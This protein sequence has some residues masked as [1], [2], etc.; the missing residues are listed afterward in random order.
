MQFRTLYAVIFD[1]KGTLTYLTEEEH[2]LR[3]RGAEAATETL[4]AAGLTLPRA[5]FVDKYLEALTFAERK[6][7]L[8]QEE[9]LATDTL[10]FLLQFYG[11]PHPDPALIRRAVDATYAPVVEASALY[12]DAMIT[13]Q[14]LR[15]RGLK[16]GIL[17]NTQD[18]NAAHAIVSRLG[19]DAQVDM[20]VTSAGMEGRH[21]KP[22][23]EAWDPFWR[24]WDVL[25]Y[26]AVMVGDDLVEDILGALN[27]T[28]W[29]IWV[30]RAP[31]GSE[32]ERAI[33][34]DAVVEALA[35]VPDVIDRWEAEP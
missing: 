29:T 22:A 14:A 20:I 16:V 34:A 30:R 27:A 7:A 23:A 15:E 11:Y 32:L 31:A 8:E 19:L 21:R 4:I 13:L 18:D 33:R 35:D 9:H 25:P 2:L 10:V 1:L 17:I 6:S 3:R 5:E 12:D 28:M 26:E 24:T